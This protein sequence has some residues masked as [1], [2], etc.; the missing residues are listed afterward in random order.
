M[1]DLTTAIRDLAALLRCLLMIG[2]ILPACETDS[3]DDEPVCDLT[4]STELLAGKVATGPVMDGA[5]DDA[6]WDCLQTLTVDVNA[7]VVYTPEGSPDGDSYP[8]LTETE[9]T[10]RAVYTDTH[11]Y[12]VAQW[13]DPTYSLARYPWLKAEDGTWAQLVNKDSTGHENT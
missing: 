13:D 1:R 2:V 8:G 4:S 11:L 10:L 7:N 9:V 3:D 12:M 6:A 5:A